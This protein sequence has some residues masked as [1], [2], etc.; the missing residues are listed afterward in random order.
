M[1][2]YLGFVLDGVQI[3]GNLSK[4]NDTREKE[5]GYG[6]RIKEGEEENEEAVNGRW[7]GGEMF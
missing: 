6:R 7:R 2:P 4:C 1:T 3:E 5:G